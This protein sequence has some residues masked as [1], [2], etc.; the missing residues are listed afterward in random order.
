LATVLNV[1]SALAYYGWDGFGI[2]DEQWTLIMLTAAAAIAISVF[3][4]FRDIAYGLVVIWAYSALI[5]RHFYDYP[6][7]AY[8]C[9]VVIALFAFAITLAIR[10]KLRTGQ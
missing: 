7:I 3:W 9:M 2:P 5:V 10:G 4:K 6:N 1:S 8:L